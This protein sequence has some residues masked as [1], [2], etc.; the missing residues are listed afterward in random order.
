MFEVN[1]IKIHRAQPSVAR[2]LYLGDDDMDR[3]AV[4]LGCILFKENYSFHYIP[5]TSL[6]PNDLV[7]DFFDLL[8]ISDYPAKNFQPR[9]F[10]RI[11]KWVEDG[12]SLLM[13]GGWESFSGL[14]LEYTATPLKSLLPVNMLDHDDRCNL[15]HGCLILPVEEH[16]VTRGLNWEAPPVIGGFNRVSLKAGA[17]LIL[18]GHTVHLEYHQGLGYRL[19]DETLPML[20]SMAVGHGRA[21]ALMFDLAPHW[22][23]GM[24]DWYQKRVTI[25]FNDLFVE[26]GDQYYQFVANL[27]RFCSRKER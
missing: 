7:L 24:V 8:I 9:Q 13:I 17:E 27:L 15:C 23:G 19:D 16:E 6:F 5:S 25:R 20:A 21:T 2:V 14:N 1:T 26:V 3:A 4:Y 10:E 11:E 22:I 12:G 18:K